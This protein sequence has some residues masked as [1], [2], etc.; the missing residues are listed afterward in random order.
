MNARERAVA[1]TKAAVRALLECGAA[2]DAAPAFIFRHIIMAVSTGLSEAVVTRIINEA[3]IGMLPPTPGKRGDEDGKVDTK[4]MVRVSGPLA[5]R[6]TAWPGGPPISETSS[7]VPP[8]ALSSSQP[9]ACAATEVVFPGPRSSNSAGTITAR[10]LHSGVIRLMKLK[11]E[12]P[13]DL[14]SALIGK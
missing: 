14:E 5:D 12:V 6:L 8:S 3:A 7:G 11:A 4:V 2:H 9:A 1:V 13:P 10:G